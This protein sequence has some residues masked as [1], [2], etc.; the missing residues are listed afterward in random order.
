MKPVYKI[1]AVRKK[2][3]AEQAGLKPND[4]LE[5]LNGKLVNKMTLSEIEHFMQINEHQEITIDVLRNNQ[6]L[7]FNFILNIPFT[8]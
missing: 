7:K 1:E 6:P 5:R 8:E 2:S 4:Q 3:N